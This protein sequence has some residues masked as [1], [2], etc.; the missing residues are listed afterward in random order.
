MY[1]ANQALSFVV[2]VRDRK[3]FSENF[4]QLE[5]IHQK[6]LLNGLRYLRSG[7]LNYRLFV[8]GFLEKPLIWYEM[9]LSPLAPLLALY[10]IIVLRRRP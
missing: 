8:P 7:G 5:L 2:F 1:G 3:L 6:Q 10:H 4:E 9:H